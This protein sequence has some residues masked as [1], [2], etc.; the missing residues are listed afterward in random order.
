[1]SRFWNLAGGAPHGDM[2]TKP[3]ISLE[4]SA[5]QTFS[6]YWRPRR[7]LDGLTDAQDGFLTP[8]TAFGR[9]Y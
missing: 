9:A 6:A 7:P 4:L 2:T 1:M 8:K 5:K 3:T